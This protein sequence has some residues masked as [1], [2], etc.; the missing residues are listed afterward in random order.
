MRAHRGEQLLHKIQI[1]EGWNELDLVFPGPFGKH[2]DP[3]TLTR[4]WEKLARKAGNAGL[5]LH[6]LRHSH[7][8]GMIRTG[9][10]SQVVQER[11]GH[12]SAA[13]TLQVYGHVSAG[14]QE[15]AAADFAN[16][17]AQA[18]G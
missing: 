17:M 12:A 10:H 8:A 7:A 3:A 9:T 1:S 5:Q 13:F 15:Q 6:D 11:L 4:N 16:L 2:L 14:M 18:S